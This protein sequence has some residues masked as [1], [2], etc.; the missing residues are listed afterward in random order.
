[1]PLQAARGPDGF[2]S[3]EAYDKER[4][5]LDAQV[6]RCCYEAVM[7]EFPAVQSEQ[8]M[9]WSEPRQWHPQNVQSGCVSKPSNSHCF[10]Y[11]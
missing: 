4:L 5:K 8:H 2:S 11:K 3:V 10:L 9:S 1:V 7:I 6:S